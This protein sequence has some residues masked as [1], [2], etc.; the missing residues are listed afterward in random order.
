MLGA[1]NMKFNGNHR[2]EMVG[3]IRWGGTFTGRHKLPRPVLNGWVAGGGVRAY[4]FFVVVSCWYDNKIIENYYYDY[5]CDYFTE[6]NER[7]F[8]LL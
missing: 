6:S 5:R 4:M 1:S 7:L 3:L 2:V 8:R